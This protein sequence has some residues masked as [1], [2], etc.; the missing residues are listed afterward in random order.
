MEYDSKELIRGPGSYS[1]KTHDNVYDT[2]IK[3]IPTPPAIRVLR[4]LVLFSIKYRGA[5]LGD[6]NFLYLK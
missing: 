6:H 2:T 4:V 1:L 3:S 5:A